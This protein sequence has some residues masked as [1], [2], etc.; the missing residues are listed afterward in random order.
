MRVE[1]D[2]ILE[3]IHSLNPN[4]FSQFKQRKK[5]I[6]PHSLPPAE[7]RIT[8][9]TESVSWV[10]WLLELGNFVLCTSLWFSGGICKTEL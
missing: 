2:E 7:L 10:R 5:Y 1:L 8:T 4:S 3:Q 6:S 9:S